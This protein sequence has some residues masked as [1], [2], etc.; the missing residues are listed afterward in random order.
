MKMVKIC[1]ILSLIVQGTCLL[2]SQQAPTLTPE[3]QEQFDSQKLT[4]TGYR[5]ITIS[6]YG[7]PLGDSGF[8][9]GSKNWEVSKGY[10]KIDEPDFLRMLG[11]DKE[12]LD[13]QTHKNSKALLTWGGFGIAVVG[14]IVILAPV[15]SPP[16]GTDSSGMSTILAGG[17]ISLGGTV[18]VLVGSSMPPNITTYGRASALADKYNAQLLIKIAQPAPNGDGSSSDKSL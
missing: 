14:L 5:I 13:A 15:F 16:T 1:L 12:A 10:D 2:F 3:Q 7:S 17:A 11:F 9:P 6:Q 18:L 8:G 4:V